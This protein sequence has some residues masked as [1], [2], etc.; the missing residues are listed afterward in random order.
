MRNI[1]K[2]SF[3]TIILILLIIISEIVLIP[4]LN[5]RKNGIFKQ[6]NYELLGE[7]KD[8]ID[9]IFLGDSLIYSSVSPMEIWNNYGYT[10]F[11]CTEAAQVMK[12]SHNYLKFAIKN[13]HPKIVIMEASVIFRDPTNQNFKNKAANFF[14]QLV[15]IAKYHD[16]WKKYADMKSKREW[17]NY[18]KGYKYITNI[19]ESKIK[20]YMIYSEEYYEI[21][22]QNNSYL[23]EI[24]DL[25]NK[26]NIKLVLVSFPSQNSWNYE[27]HNTTLKVA[28]ENNIE[29]IDLNLTNLNIDWKTDTKDRGK[30]LNYLGAKKVSN[31]IGK[32][33]KDTNLL[34]DHRDDINYESW[35]KA[36]KKYERES[37]NN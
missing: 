27:K 13:Q 31:Y 26:N 24:I 2:A 14:K 23:K 6:A 30:H 9:V 16:N 11:D 36:L 7:K 22:V 12:D 21:P 4:G 25:C 34:I 18:S 19:K 33:L 10:S 3:F 15:P 32:Y 1:I 35:Y 37:F 29:F 20:N 17:I 28:N 5:I 8:T